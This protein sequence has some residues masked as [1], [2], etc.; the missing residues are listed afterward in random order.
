M[1]KTK[2]AVA[3]KRITFFGDSICHGQHISVADIFV[4]RLSAHCGRH[5]PSPVIVENRSINGNTTRQALE[6]LSF[7]VTSNAPDLVYVQFGLND[8]N[9]WAT[10]FG[11]P[12]VSLAAYDANLREIVRK[13]RA[14]GAATV[15]LATNH[16]CRL[17]AEYETRLLQYNEAVRTLSRE[18]GTGLFD[19][20][21]APRP[22]DPQAML[23]QDGIHLSEAGH[24]FYFEAL[25]DMF[26]AA[27]SALPARATAAGAVTVGV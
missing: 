27:V 19:V 6:R 2:A 13:L 11:E 3:A 7:D 23:L 1:S 4:A 20:R 17:G 21:A 16:E 5:Y 10:D 22:F 9:V 26:V 25:K 18:L 14:A 24:I 12:R 8:C 15:I